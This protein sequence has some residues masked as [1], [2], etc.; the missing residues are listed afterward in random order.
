MDNLYE[1][2]GKLIIQAEIIQGQIN[3]AKRL[4]QQELSKKP[5]PVAPKKEGGDCGDKKSA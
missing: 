4:I 1:R 5:A 2:Y 3:E